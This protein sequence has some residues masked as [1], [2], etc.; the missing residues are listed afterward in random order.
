MTKHSSSSSQGQLSLLVKSHF[1]EVHE[2]TQIKFQCK[3]CP[4]G[5]KWTCDDNVTRMKHHL[6]RRFVCDGDNSQA[7]ECAFVPKAVQDSILQALKNETATHVVPGNKKRKA[8]L[9]SMIKRDDE[10]S[11]VD[12]TNPKLKQQKLGFTF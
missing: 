3:Y 9:A 7:R 1:D 10:K 5:K 11:I 2:G 4:Q 6:A 8:E 12:L